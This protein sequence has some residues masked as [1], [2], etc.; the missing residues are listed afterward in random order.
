MLEK[1]YG[2]VSVRINAG[3]GIESFQVGNGDVCTFL[4][5]SRCELSQNG[6]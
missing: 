4:M 3:E 5:V 6:V 1:F 2:K